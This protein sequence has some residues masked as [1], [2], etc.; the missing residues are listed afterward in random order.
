MQLLIPHFK[1]KQMGA[2]RKIMM[3]VIFIFATQLC[4]FQAQAFSGNNFYDLGFKNLKTVIKGKLLNERGEPLAGCTVSEKGTQNFSQSAADGSFTIDVAGQS[5][6]IIIS[7]VG[8]ETQEVK[9]GSLNN[10][11]ITLVPSASNMDQ[12][13]VVGYSSQKKATVTGAISTVKG[14]DLIKSRS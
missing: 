3:S 6:I 5:S 11:T 12:V 1:S 8:Y 4:L 9:V 14:A 7:Y 10:Y 13:V 2:L